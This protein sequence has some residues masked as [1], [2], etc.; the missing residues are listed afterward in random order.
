MRGVL[1]HLADARYGRQDAE[2]QEVGGRSE[3]AEAC[4]GAGEEP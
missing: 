1:L 3:S 4:E 2:S